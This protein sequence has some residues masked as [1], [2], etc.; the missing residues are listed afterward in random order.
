MTALCDVTKA[1][2]LELLDLSQKIIN[3]P[4]WKNWHTR[5]PINNGFHPGRYLLFKWH[6]CD[7]HQPVLFQSLQHGSEDRQPP[8]TPHHDKWL[9]RWNGNTPEVM[10]QWNFSPLS[11]G[12][13]RQVRGYRVLTLRPWV[14]CSSCLMFSGGPPPQGL[15]ISFSAYFHSELLAFLL[16]TQQLS[17]Q[18]VV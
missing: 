14:A 4:E 5:G 3:V 6:L 10:S 11:F 16:P 2:F 7:W 13:L 8:S 9:P 18:T 12:W 17:P 1:V 15:W